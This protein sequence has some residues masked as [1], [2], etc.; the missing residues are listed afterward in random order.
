[1][2]RVLYAEKVEEAVTTLLYLSKLSPTTIRI[3]GDSILFIDEN[4]GEIFNL[5]L[6]RGL[7]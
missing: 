5:E 3:I 6:K 7:K 2:E 4:S 1:M